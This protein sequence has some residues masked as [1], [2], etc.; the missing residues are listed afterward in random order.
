MLDLMS[1]F[2]GIASPSIW[3]MDISLTLASEPATF[4]NWPRRRAMTASL[5]SVVKS[6]EECASVRVCT[7]L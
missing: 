4:T 5:S 3:K 6:R 7:G 2:S 1:I